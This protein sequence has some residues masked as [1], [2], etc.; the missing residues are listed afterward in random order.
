MKTGPSHD[1]LYS[2]PI[3]TAC[4]NTYLRHDHGYLL[5]LDQKASNIINYS[6][7]LLAAL[8]APS[9]V[10]L[11]VSR[12]E[13]SGLAVGPNGSSGFQRGIVIAIEDQHQS[14]IKFGVLRKRG[15]VDQK[16]DGRPIGI[17]VA[18]RQPDGLLLR[19]RS[20]RSMRQERSIAKDQR[21]AL[22]ASSR[23]SRRA[24]TTARQPRS[25][26]LEQRWQNLFNR[27]PSSW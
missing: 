24:F 26:L 21:R 5:S 6:I 27:L 19:P 4:P 8:P 13:P 2:R 23:S 25:K 9:F 22:I 14:L 18:G 10:G 1:E 3:I 7:S 15:I 20:C 16:S 12:L 11:P 17:V